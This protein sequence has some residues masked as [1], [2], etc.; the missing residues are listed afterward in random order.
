MEC[1]TG[2]FI[3]LTG[4]ASNGVAAGIKAFPRVIIAD[5]RPG[6]SF[7]PSRS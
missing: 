7:R 6:F 5:R 2:Q 4:A 1:S 3:L